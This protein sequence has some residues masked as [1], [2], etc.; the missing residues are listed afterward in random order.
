MA[1]NLYELQR[2]Y[3]FGGDIHS[4]FEISA[5]IKIEE[6]SSRAGLVL[7]RGDR[8]LGDRENYFCF[9]LD[10]SSIPA[11]LSIYRVGV[12]GEDTD[13]HPWITVPVCRVDAPGH[14][15][16]V[17]AENRHGEHV[18][19]V[20]VLGGGAE[21]WLD[22][23]WIDAEWI[24]HPWGGTVL[25]PR[26]I[27][28]F[29]LGKTESYP[30]LNEVGYRLPPGQAAVFSGLTVREAGASGRIVFRD[31]RV[32]RL[33]S[34]KE[35]LL[36]TFDPLRERKRG[37]KEKRKGRRRSV[38]TKEMKFSEI[39]GLQGM[40]PL[41]RFVYSVPKTDFPFEDADRAGLTIESLCAR[42]P[43]WNADSMV[44][45][46]ECVAKNA[47]SG[48]QI[49]YPIYTEEE[50]AADPEKARTGL[51]YFPAKEKGPFALVCAGG[52]YL[53]VENMVEAFPVAMRLNEL[54][55]PAFALQYRAGTL[56]AA[57]KSAE[58][59]HRAL[60]YIFAHAESLGVEKRYIAYGFSAGGHLVSQL[61][62]D[63]HG[64]RANGTPKPEM[65]GLAYPLVNF[66]GQVDE[67]LWSFMAARM[68]GSL[69][70]AERETYSTI[71][72]ADE[73]YPPTFLMQT[74]DDEQVSFR[75]NGLAFY[76][77]LQSLGVPCRLKA[78]EHG[79]HGLGLGENSG[80]EGWV[81]ES[82]KFWKESV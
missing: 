46:L 48:R 68:F 42:F 36:R 13:A 73:T 71:R 58:D 30:L 59:I 25:G 38:I 53:G 6:G 61:G 51:V 82:V 18:L 39:L 44:K 26:R 67:N 3:G 12:T 41:T 15:P 45:G 37:Q 20:R 56:D 76:E 57:K 11:A 22:G 64:C 79:P 75:A 50:L 33:V 5:G 70:E 7:G 34:G 72:H 47:A 52:A 17:T 31:L 27:D 24:R 28:P 4:A 10:V 19:R 63:V 21:T 69:G 43:A 77:K 49:V 66:E 62:S 35:T 9:E 29:R 2:G 80:A 78:V 32:C 54:G 23:R 1:L 14:A 8:R 74:K 81:D 16:V 60:A 55:I 65:L 40:E